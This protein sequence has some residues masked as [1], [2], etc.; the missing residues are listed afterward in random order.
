MISRFYKVA[1]VRR[2]AKTTS[3][4]ALQTYVEGG[5]AHFLQRMF[6]LHDLAVQKD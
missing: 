3:S 2:R 5:I 6:H 4:L 1:Q